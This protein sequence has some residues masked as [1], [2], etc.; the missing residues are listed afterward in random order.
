MESVR[1]RNGRMFGM[2]NNEGM[3]IMWNVSDD[4]KPKPEPESL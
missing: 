2:E 4:L 3:F 1:E